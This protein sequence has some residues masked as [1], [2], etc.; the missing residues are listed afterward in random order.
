M[1]RTAH[2]I[3]ERLRQSGHE[4]YYAGGSVRDLL[5]GKMPQDIDIVTS[6]L[7]E[8]IEAMLGKTI[9]LGKKFGVIVA[10]ED[11]HHFE[12]ATFRSDS[13]DSDGRRPEAITFSSARE[14]ALRRDFTINGMFYDPIAGEVIDYVGGQQDL[15]DGVI[16][17][18]GDPDQ[19]IREDYLRM[20]RAVRFRVTLGFDYDPATRRAIEQSGQFVTKTSWERIADEINKMLKPDEVSYT[21][22]QVFEALDEVGLL[23]Y[24]LPEIE[25]LKR[26]PQPPAYHQEGDVYVHTMRCLKSLHGSTDPTV[27]WGVMLHDVG[28]QTTIKFEGD[29]ISFRGHEAAGVEIGQ[30][31]LDRFRFRKVDKEKILWLIENHMLLLNFERMRDARRRQWFMHPWFEDLMQVFKADAIGTKPTELSDYNRVSQLYHEEKERK[32]LEPPKKLLTGDDLIKEFKL[33]PGR[34]LGD[35]LDALH[36]AQL[37][38]R[39]QTREEAITWVRQKLEAQQNT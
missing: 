7:P 20:L 32:L 24:V 22:N 8:K 9:P 16:R 35:V 33:E 38:G 21:F 3:V 36:E 18:I 34:Q 19:R 28:K 30:V 14:D 25:A 15:K 11:G 1:R 13:P 2:G 26:V 5:R 17:F 37:E 27:I 6:A 23:Q 31:V 12:I 29:D 4:A 39:I 10:V